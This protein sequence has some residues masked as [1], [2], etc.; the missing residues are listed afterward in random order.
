[1]LPDR[2]MTDLSKDIEAAVEAHR[3]E[4]LEASTMLFAVQKTSG[5]TV[6][7]Q[8]IAAYKRLVDAHLLITGV[9]AAALLRVNGKITPITVTS[10]K[11]SALFASFVIGM[12]SCE[13]AI[14]EGRYLQASALLRQEME[15]VAQIKQIQAGKQCEQKANVKILEKSLRCLYSELSNAAHVSKHHI[16]RAA[17]TWN[18]S[19][20]DLPEL[21]SGTSYFPVFD[22]GL[23]RR[24]FSLHLMLIIRLIE[25]FSID[26][27]EQFK[28]DGFTDHEV[29]AVKAALQ[30]MQFEGMAEGDSN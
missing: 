10:E 13:T 24:S 29:E 3:S 16:V 18:I 22:E 26:L 1:M 8:S 9:L 11:R 20:L 4:L 28:H 5:D 15:T 21:T 19:D 30:L 7:K 14:V 23:A 2:R 12:E 17:T 27:N 6:R 25:E